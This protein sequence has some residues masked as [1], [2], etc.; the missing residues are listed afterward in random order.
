[1]TET[2]STTNQ[3]LFGEIVEAAENAKQEAAKYQVPLKEERTSILLNVEEGVK[4]LIGSLARKEKIEGI[5]LETSA[6]EGMPNSFVGVVMYLVTKGLKAELD[7]EFDNAPKSLKQRGGNAI[8][9]KIE[10]KKRLL[11]RDEKNELLAKTQM[12]FYEKQIA[13]GAMTIEQSLL[14]IKDAFDRKK[15][16]EDMGYMLPEGKTKYPYWIDDESKEEGAE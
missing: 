10:G 11:T 13:A 2:P 14:A 12:S 3:V 1:M 15:G 8:D 16:F 4:D 5:D 7:I 9:K 6:Y